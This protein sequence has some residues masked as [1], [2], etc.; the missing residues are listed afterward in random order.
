MAF[1]NK[2]DGQNYVKQYRVS[3]NKGSLINC[4]RYISPYTP[5]VYE[6]T[7]APSYNFGVFTINY[8]IYYP[9]VDLTWKI[10]GGNN[11]IYLPKDTP[12]IDIKVKAVEG[13]KEIYD[14]SYKGSDYGWRN[15]LLCGVP[16][17]TLNVTYDEVNQYEY[18]FNGELGFTSYTNKPTTITCSTGTVLKN[19]YV[20]N[21]VTQNYYSGGSPVSNTL[22]G[23]FLISNGEYSVSWTASNGNYGTIT[24]SLSADFGPSEV[25]FE[26]NING[27]CFTINQAY[28]DACY[29]RYVVENPEL[30]G[31]SFKAMESIPPT[32]ILGELTDEGYPVEW[33]GLTSPYFYFTNNQEFKISFP[34]RKN[35]QNL[36]CSC[37]SH[38]RQSYN[39]ET[40]SAMYMLKNS[41]A[42]PTYI[43]NVVLKYT[44]HPNTGEDA[45]PPYDTRKTN[46]INDYNIKSTKDSHY[47]EEGDSKT[48]SGGD[49]I[50][51]DEN[52][53]T[54]EIND[55]LKIQLKNNTTHCMLSLEEKTICGINDWNFYNCEIIG[56]GDN[57]YLY[58]QSNDAYIYQDLYRPMYIEENDTHHLL[59]RTEYRQKH[60]THFRYME[61][62]FKKIVETEEEGVVVSSEEVMFTPPISLI[63]KP[64]G[65]YCSGH[66]WTATFDNVTETYDLLTCNGGGL[67]T[68]DE[69]LSTIQPEDYKLYN[70][71]AELGDEDWGLKYLNEPPQTNR[72]YL[73]NVVG[74]VKIPI[75]P[76]TKIIMGELKSVLSPGINMDNL[77]LRWHYTDEVSDFNYDTNFDSNNNPIV[78]RNLIT[79]VKNFYNDDSAEFYMINSSNY[80]FLNATATVER[81][82]G[83]PVV[84]NITN[85]W[86]N[87]FNIGKARSIMIDMYFTDPNDPTNTIHAYHS[88]IGDT[89]NQ[90]FY[91]FR[92]LSVPHSFRVG[93]ELSYAEWFKNGVKYTFD[94]YH[95][96]KIKEGQYYSKQIPTHELIFQCGA[97]YKKMVRVGDHNPKSSDAGP[98]SGDRADTFDCY[99]SRYVSILVNGARCGDIPDLLRIRTPRLNE[100]ITKPFTLNQYSTGTISP[101]NNCTVIFPRDDLGEFKFNITNYEADEN[102]YYPIR[103]LSG[104]QFARVHYLHCSNAILN[105]SLTQ[106]VYTVPEV[107]KITCN[108]MARF[109][110]SYFDSNGNWHGNTIYLRGSFGAM[111]NGCSNELTTIT[112]YVKERSPMLDTYVTQQ[113]N[114]GV[115]T[116]TELP[117]EYID[118]Y[119]AYKDTKT[120]NGEVKDRLHSTGESPLTQWRLNSCSRVLETVYDGMKYTLSY[121][122]VKSGKILRN[123]A[124]KIL[125]NAQHKILRGDDM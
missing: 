119:G 113:T 27:Q 24:Y 65:N 5:N 125:R 108:N 28:Q 57:T 10:T 85:D 109:M 52:E 75:P 26:S 107:D 54:W 13:Y 35:V 47:L 15:K 73:P 32:Y 82:N 122:Y 55:C 105:G 93:V 90:N 86:L 41:R 12:Y 97:E 99:E 18:Y 102:G 11:T 83:E 16:E 74:R 64:Y 30:G 106:D 62:T 7:M 77:Q 76:N 94:E 112:G 117:I 6:F 20:D 95:T 103:A 118:V 66:T 44:E 2:I 84:F 124:G 96:L 3:L 61:S 81:D 68:T 120:T 91:R 101:S 116:T 14:I 45:H 115:I 70:E 71:D 72:G 79:C 111:Y 123:L 25:D 92:I 56:S 67:S 8:G 121:V 78:Y 17:S 9:N 34:E 19:S 43:G 46:G 29:Y 69:C 48:T 42:I 50:D 100:S 87:T 33:T 59:N 88:F 63:Y 114:D 38:N 23:D 53:C 36:Q 39:S 1:L 98:S 22:Y 60:F 21:S 80:N 4:E 31:G 49:T 51:F 37:T 58:A 104:G 40:G 89:A 110:R